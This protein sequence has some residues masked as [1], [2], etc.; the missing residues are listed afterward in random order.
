MHI[1][2][3]ALGSLGDILPCLA[4]GG[5]LRRAGHQVRF[6]TFENFSSLVEGQALEF[7]PI[8][9]DSRV[10]VN[11]ASANML[12]L[13]RTFASLGTSYAQDLSDPNLLETDLFINQLPAGLFGHDLAEKAGV[14]MFQA[15]A[16][17][18]TRTRY[19]PLVGSPEI[20]LPGYNRMTY[21]LAEQMAWQMM[22]RAVNRWR[23][24]TLGLP[25]HPVHGYF[26]QL[27][28]VRRPVLNAF[29]PAVVPVPPDWAS[30]VHVTGYWFPQDEFW[31]P[32]D[33][34]QNFIDNGSQPV[35]FGFG[36]MPLKDPRQLM[37]NILE[38]LEG[39]GQRGVIHSGW[40]GLGKADLPDNVY[41]LD[42]APYEWLFPK[43][44]AIVH[45][46]GSGTTA[47]ALRSGKPSLILPSVFDQYYWAKRIVSLGVGPEPIPIGRLMSRQRGLAQL[48]SAIEQATQN[49]EM[50]QQATD[51]GRKIKAEDGLGKAIEIIQRQVTIA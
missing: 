16:M 25:A 35:F 41:L 50:R 18:L 21:L 31:Q 22:R 42:Y 14:I 5:S 10:L 11:Q 47:Q 45:H 7:Y 49:A 34:L 9:G 1:T 20:P 28:T 24:E 48:Q 3:I 6:I 26:N 29:S 8:R 32:P 30:Y 13:A 46:G 19:F 23:R 33:D 17:P 12:S 44:A 43:M 36:S 15:A 27:A 37:K 40:A 2:F 51:L 39:C 38:T 4:L